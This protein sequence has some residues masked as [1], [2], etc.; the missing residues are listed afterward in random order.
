M[1][2][3]LEKETNKPANTEAV[4]EAPKEHAAAQLLEAN[5]SEN[6]ESED[7][8]VFGKSIK[9]TTPT[10]QQRKYML[11]NVAGTRI[12]KYI[13]PKMYESMYYNQQTQFPN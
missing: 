13:D 3:V 1:F 6:S 2:E 8:F 7:N 5:S 11:S 4:S 9:N 12:N 10:H